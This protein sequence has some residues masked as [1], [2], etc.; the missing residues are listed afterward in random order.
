MNGILRKRLSRALAVAG[1]GAT[2]FAPAGE[3]EAS[4]RSELKALQGGCVQI[5]VSTE[6]TL[7]VTLV[8]VDQDV[9]EVSLS[10]G[11]AFFAIDKLIGFGAC[12]L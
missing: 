12:P 9:I 5:V 7:T 1:L 4:I 10:Q 2:L 8:K 6:V 11:N 3:A